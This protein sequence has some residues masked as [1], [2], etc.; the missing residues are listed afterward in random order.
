MKKAETNKWSGFNQTNGRK[1]MS[2]IET[3]TINEL[4]IET[5]RLTKQPLYIH[6]N[7]AMRCYNRIIRPHAILNSRKFGIP[8][9]VCQ[10]HI[11][12]FNNMK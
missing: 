2:S 9:N 12:S 10:L 7:D 11:K 4:I 1:N 5:R 6:Q 8:E 3:A